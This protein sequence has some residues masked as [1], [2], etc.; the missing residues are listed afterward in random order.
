MK[1]D[2]EKIVLFI[3]GLLV[4]YIIYKLYTQR[5]EG[6]A[7]CDIESQ[8]VGNPMIKRDASNL[9]YNPGLPNNGEPKKAVLGF[10]DLSGWTG[11][12]DDEL[13]VRFG[14][15]M[16]LKSI[17]IGGYGKFKIRVE[18]KDNNSNV[19][20]WRDLIDANASD[21][22]K[23]FFNGGNTDKAKASGT[24]QTASHCF[25]LSVDGSDIVLCEAIKFIV[26]EG[27]A[28]N[29]VKAQF[30]V[31]GIEPDANPGYRYSD[32][33]N[34]IG[35]GFNENNNEISKNAGKFDWTGETGNSDPKCTIR[36]EAI[37]SVPIANKIISFV[38]IEPK[39][40]NYITSYNIAFKYQ[41]STVTR[42]ITDI[43]GNSGPGTKSRYYF[44]YPLLANELVIKPSSSSAYEPNSSPPSC[45]LKFFGK[46][47]DSEEQEN[48]LKA[49]Q[50]TYYKINR[51]KN[52]KS[53]CPPINTLINKQAEIQ[54]LCDA[55]EQSDEIE[56]EKKKIDTNKLY[57]L[58][59]AKQ[60]K[61]IQELQDKIKDMRDANKFFDNIEDRNKI[62]V[63]KYQ[64]EM[65]KKLKQLVKQRLDKQMGV[66]FNLAVKD[67]A[68]NSPANNVTVESFTSNI[69]NTFK[70]KHRNLPLPPET[71][72]EEFVG[73]H[74]F[75]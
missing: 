43:P 18:V 73:S 69:S 14:K 39:G 61:E 65:D 46:N 19:K 16:E 8:Y 70:N 40:N 10:G 13:I 33:L 26:A 12:K 35:K 53:T 23:L 63:F 32:D 15:I 37:D 57:H 75:N 51:S 25:N 34:N 1:F 68:A 60:R 74:Y 52:T 20:V 42:H 31:L 47:I 55:L 11:N 7:V 24:T 48:V 72:Y 28:S 29:S 30:E 45:L 66:N 44:K 27:N 54:Q 41:G 59:L 67:S 49:E 64:E 62:A 21:D 9:L 6:F 36:F 2:Y 58:K 22:N 56:F 38:E 50:E 5:I 3:L 4:V 71:F 17:I